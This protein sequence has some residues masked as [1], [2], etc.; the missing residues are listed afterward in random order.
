MTVHQ[1]LQELGGAPTIARELG[2]PY[3][4]VV[5]WRQRNSI[6]HW[7]MPALAALAISKGKAVPAEIGAQAA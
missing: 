6:P 2:V 5:T 3:T 7:R 1:F 4:T